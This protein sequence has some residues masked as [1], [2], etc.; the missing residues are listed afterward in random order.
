[1]ALKEGRCPNCGS[2]LHLDPKADKGHC[3][4]CDAVFQNSDAFSIAENPAGHTFPNEPQPKYEGPDLRSN[5]NGQAAARPKNKPSQPQPSKPKPPPPQTYEMKEPEKVPD[6]RLPS[7]VKIRLF[8]AFLVLLLLITGITVPIVMRRDAVRSDLTAAIPSIAS[9]PVN[10]ERD[11]SIWHVDN[12]YI[13]VATE[14]MV[15]EDELVGFFKALC[16]KRASL[17]AI[18]SDQF[19]D[20]YG[21]VKLKLVYPEGGYLVTHPES[22]SALAVGEAI[23]K[24]P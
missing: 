8:L 4:F 19:E 5:Q 20:V 11:V 18:D 6:V 3:L 10:P 21:S 12:D 13:M 9:F 14:E 22:E 23:K 7:K 16:E 1:M 2:I 17:L 15:S 24:L